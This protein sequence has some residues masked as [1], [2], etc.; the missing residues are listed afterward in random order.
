MRRALLTPLLFSLACSGSIGGKNAEPRPA[1]DA[2]RP[3][4]RRDAGLGGADAE[5]ASDGGITTLSTAEVYARLRPTCGG[6]HS[7]DARPY[8]GSL[9][10]FDSLIVRD[11]RWIHPGQPEA[12]ALLGLLRGDGALKMPPV[13][14]VFAVLADKG[15][16]QITLPELEAWIRAL[17]V[18]P[19]L[20]SGGAAGIRRKTAEQVLT[21]LRTQLG[22]EDADLV[23]ASGVTLY[24]VLYAPRSAD[25]IPRIDPYGNAA[26]L[27]ESLGGPSFLEGKKRNNA[28]TQG[29]VQ[30]LTHV[31]QAWC[32]VAVAKPGNTALLRFATLSDRSSAADGPAKIR[33]NLGYLMER[34][35][36]DDPS[37]EDID[38]LYRSVFVPYEA[39]G[40][41]L[42]WTAVCAALVR[43][44]LWLSY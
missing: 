40:T 1:D 4:E 31:S 21:T 9:E 11:P 7:V 25:E 28:L 15:Q 19:P 27:F 38:D 22:L 10:A 17:T 43:D 29:F 13:G 20:P 32:K 42:A 3:A 30:T 14:D 2:G 24:R 41:D 34:M 26:A 37:A 36:G 18:A 33:Q 8:F 5:T 6:C 35:L 12:S 44:P 23:D 39:S 16:T